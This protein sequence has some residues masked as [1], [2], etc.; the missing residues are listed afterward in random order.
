MLQ[1]VNTASRERPENKA[2]PRTGKYSTYIEKLNDAWRFFVIH[3]WQSTAFHQQMKS[4]QESEA[5]LIMD[6]P[7]N[8]TFLKWFQLQMDFFQTKQTTGLSDEAGRICL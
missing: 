7:E 3:E 4:L 8:F 2:V 5:M 6:F 1:K